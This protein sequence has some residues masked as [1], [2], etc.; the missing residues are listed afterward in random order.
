MELRCWHRGRCMISIK[1]VSL[2][3]Q[4]IFG[5]FVYARASRIVLWMGGAELCIHLGLNHTP[6][7][8]SSP[9]EWH[10]QHSAEKLLVTCL[11]SSEIALTP[12]F[13]FS[14][15]V[16]L[17]LL[18]FEL[19][20]LEKSLLI[21]SSKETVPVDDGPSCILWSLMYVSH[22]LSGRLFATIDTNL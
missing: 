6:Y 10:R 16:T 9:G 20:W 13:F 1:H 22:R 18:W 3:I 14:L 15:L 11:K 8:V 7:S 4:S 5:G 17:F 12:P 21:I 2:L 19:S